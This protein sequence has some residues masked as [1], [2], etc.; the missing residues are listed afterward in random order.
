MYP[1]LDLFFRHFTVTYPIWNYCHFENL[2]EIVWYFYITTT[3]KNINIRYY[4]HLW[5]FLSILLHSIL[6]LFDIITFDTITFRYNYLSILL[7]LS[8]K[9]DFLTIY[10]IL[11]RYCYC[12]LLS[13]LFPFDTITRFHVKIEKPKIISSLK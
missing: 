5:I 8:I 6:L 11:F 13:I 4:Y 1:I 7:L 10:E 12:F 3:I 2:Q 9:F